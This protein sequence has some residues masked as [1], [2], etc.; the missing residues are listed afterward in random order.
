LYTSVLNRL[1]QIPVQFDLIESTYS[2]VTLPAGEELIGDGRWL[3]CLFLKAGDVK[4]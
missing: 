1:K 4:A 3:K 2:L